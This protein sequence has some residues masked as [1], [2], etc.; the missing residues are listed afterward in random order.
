MKSKYIENE[1]KQEFENKRGVYFEINMDITR[2]LQIFDDYG[3]EYAL[4]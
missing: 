4:S 3:R 1:R 2:I